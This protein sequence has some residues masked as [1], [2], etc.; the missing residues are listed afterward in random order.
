MVVTLN[1]KVVAPLHS[2]KFFGESDVIVHEYY[3]YNI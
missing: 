2:G 3:L 1:V